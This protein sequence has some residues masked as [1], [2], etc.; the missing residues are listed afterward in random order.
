MIQ[1]FFR[2]RNTEKQIRYHLTQCPAVNTYRSLI[3]VPPQW[4]VFLLNIT[5][6]QGNICGIVIFPP[7]MRFDIPPDS[8]QSVIKKL[9]NRLKFYKKTYD[10]CIQY[11]MMYIVDF[12]VH[13]TLWNF[14]D[15]FNCKFYCQLFLFCN[16]VLFYN[17]AYTYDFIF[18]CIIIVLKSN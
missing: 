13:Y 10:K 7:T 8:P 4:R 6:T 12:S 5:T 9:I 2:E 18:V 14:L 3:N 11:Y 16:S 1:F 15:K 17:S